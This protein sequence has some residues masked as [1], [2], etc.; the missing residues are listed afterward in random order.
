MAG[1]KG[2]YHHGDLRSALLAAAL[3]ILLESGVEG[4]SLRGVARRAGVSPSA[5]YNHFASKG[6][7]LAELADDRRGQA[8]RAFRAAM[9]A[10]ETPL[11]KLEALGVAYVAYAL[12][13]RAEFKLIFGGALRPPAAREVRDTPLLGLFRS[14]VGDAHTTLSGA[15]LEAAAIAAW[16]LVH[17]LAQLVID[18]PLDGLEEDAEGLARLAGRVT[19]A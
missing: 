7:L 14:A 12:E 8:G 6:A 13:H 1:Q 15:E 17:G 2:A 3:A 11:A 16:S 19:R 9:A 5:P 10:A 18:G 4:L